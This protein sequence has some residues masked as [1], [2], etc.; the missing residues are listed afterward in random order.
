LRS[1]KIR[2]H[3]EDI[4]GYERIILNCFLRIWGG[5]VC[6]AL[7]WLMI[8]TGGGFLWTQSRDFGFH[9]TRGIF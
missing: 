9:K 1:L 2:D 6:I 7:I 5:R 3:S 8:R 4:G